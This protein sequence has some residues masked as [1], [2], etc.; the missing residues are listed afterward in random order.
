M[1]GIPPIQPYP[2]PD[3]AALPVNTATW[4]VDHSRVVLLV[5]DMQHYFLAP[6]PED[7]S[8][9]LQ[10]VA[11]IQRM[12]GTGR[13][14]NTPI[15][16]TAQPGSM[17]DEQR[18]L[19][20]DF[21]GPGM[22]SEARD[23]AIIESLSPAPDDWVFTKW[24]Y[25]AFFASNL[26][27]RMRELGRDQLIV[28][29][30][31]AHVGMLATAVEAFSNDIQAFIVAD[32]VADFSSRHH[33]LAIEYAAQ[34]CAVVSTTANSH[35][36][37]PLVEHYRAERDRV[38]GDLLD[39]VLGPDRRAFALLYR[40]E[41]TG[42]GS[43]DVLVGTTSIQTRLADLPLPPAMAPPTGSPTHDLL[44]LMPYR[45]LSERGFDAMTTAHR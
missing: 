26:L 14:L 21:W 42:P 35:S 43:L 4:K 10:L 20:K 39:R 45:Q 2:L 33:Q 17:S 31:Y 44:A 11:N 24:R 34:C 22:R 19:L 5:H 9:R 40:P 13:D 16:Y 25:S 15:A 41:T 38:T 37:G 23:R 1:A 6:F 8:P 28:C 18:G 12:I 7:Q 36:T 32:A 27:T 29:G 3:I 30:I